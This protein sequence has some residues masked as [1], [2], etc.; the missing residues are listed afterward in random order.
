MATISTDTSLK[1]CQLKA[2]HRLLSLNASEHT[3]DVSEYTRAPAGSSHNAWKVLIYDKTCQ[4][5]ISPLLNVSQLRSRGVTL[6]MLA[7]SKRERI[8]D[9]PAVYFV[10]P[11]RSNISIIA[12]DCA[13]RLYSKVHIHFVSKLDRGL[14]EEFAK[15]IVASNSLDVIASVHDEYLD[16]QSLEQNLFALGNARDSYVA[17]H[18]QGVTD[19][20]MD[21]YLD[22][23]AY[24]LLSVVGC[25]GAVPVIRCPK[26]STTSP[27]P[28]ILAI[29]P[30]FGVFLFY[31][32]IVSSPT[33]S[34]SKRVAHLT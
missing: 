19:Q 2:V 33:L 18:Q 25:F 27:S 20:T 3:Y 8:P 32:S 9:V 34:L 26:V 29:G 21:A 6:H 24:G 1:E 23:I 22:Q 13:Q 30:C 4:S 10:E 16:F 12:S 7:E 31:R 11:T 17:L 14:M 28:H 15:M 5:I